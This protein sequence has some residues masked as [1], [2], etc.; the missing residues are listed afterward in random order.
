MEN[1]KLS[2]LDAIFE[3]YEQHQKQ[4]RGLRPITVRGYEFTIRQFIRATIG[5]DPIDLARLTPA[6][7]VF[8]IE[9]VRSRCRPSSIQTIGTSLRSFFRYLRVEGLCDIRLESAIPAVASWK[10]ASLPRS[11]SDS[12]YD[13]LMASLGAQT[14]CGRRDRA[15]ILCLATLGLRPGEVAALC[16]E[17]IDWRIGTL[18]LRTRKTR[19]GSILPLPHQCGSAIVEYLRKDRPHT[20][21]R[22]VFVRHSGNR[23]GEP[24]TA[25]IVTGAV[26][27]ALK[28]AEIDSPIAGAYVLRHTAATRMV[29]RGTRLK[30]VA[31]ILGH[32]NLDTTTIY[33]KVDLSTLSDVAL[34]WP[35]VMS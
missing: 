11:L 1:N 20:I 2:S 29:R 3:M 28:K 25:G 24:I 8:Y 34:P 26:N 14:L 7:I 23:K 17:D 18:H 10:L 32:R 9:S 22:Q 33:A 12:E 35:E 30:E 16:L 6:N 5:E 21:A 31:D 27:H 15:I 4:V 13:C 19:R